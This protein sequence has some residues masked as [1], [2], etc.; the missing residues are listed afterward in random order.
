MEATNTLQRHPMVRVCIGGE[1]CIPTLVQDAAEPCCQ[2]PSL[3]T[4][5]TRELISPL[6]TPPIFRRLYHTTSK[7]SKTDS[8]DPNKSHISQEVM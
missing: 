5:R 8:Y 2:L 4:S 1:G 6:T 3:L 7:M